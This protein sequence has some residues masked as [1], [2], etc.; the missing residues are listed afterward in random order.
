M[1]HKP[2]A[3]VHCAAVVG[4]LSS[5]GSPINVIR[6]NVEGSLNV[7]EAMRLAGLRRCIHLSSEEAYGVFG[8][9]ADRRDASARSGAALRHL[10][11]RGRAAR[12]QLSGPARTGGDQPAH[13]VGLRSRSA[14][15]PHPQEPGGGRAG[16]A[17]APH[18]GRRGLG[19]RSHPRGRPGQ[20]RAQG[21]RS[22]APS[23][24]CLQHRQRAG[25]HRCRVDRHRTGADTWR[26]AFGRARRLPPRR[27]GGDGAQRCARCRAVPPPSSD[28]SRA[29]TFVPGS[30]RTSMRCGR[31]RGN[32]RRHRWT[33]ATRRSRTPKPPKR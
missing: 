14:A 30:Q 23:L 20:R 18:S 1:A 17:Q 31:R 11:G 21:A 8:A 25:D 33:K 26:R 19:D 22:R 2:R 6:V 28:G 7:F 9:D 12:A 15:Q 29:T 5:L 32:E 13:L 24:R 27:P 10:Q 4:V 3:V 16:R